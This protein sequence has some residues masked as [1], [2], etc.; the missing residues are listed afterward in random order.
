MADSLGEG[1]EGGIFDQTLPRS[2]SV[3]KCHLVEVG[4]GLGRGMLVVCSTAAVC[5]AISSLYAST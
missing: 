2:C 5:L 1:S 3:M 4:V